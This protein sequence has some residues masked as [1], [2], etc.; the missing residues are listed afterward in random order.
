VLCTLRH[1]HQ[2]T[3]LDILLLTTYDRL[4]GSL[5]ENEVLIDVMN[6][7]AILSSA[8]NLAVV[9]ANSSSPPLRS[10][11]RPVWSSQPTGSIL[12]SI[13]RGGTPWSWQDILRSS[14]GS[15]P[16]EWE[17]GFSYV[18]ERLNGEIINSHL[19]GRW[20]RHLCRASECSE[21]WSRRYRRSG[22]TGDADAC[23]QRLTGDQDGR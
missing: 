18:V 3:R 10:L 1:Y 13:A 4:A 16:S 6:L 12:Q 11:H 7:Y 22:W 15:A 8:L 20:S 2:V 9:H 17:F 19:L 21:R 5:S 14:L 23:R